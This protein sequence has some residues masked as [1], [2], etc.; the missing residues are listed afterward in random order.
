MVGSSKFS[1][2]ERMAT[3]MASMML[4]AQRHLAKPRKELEEGGDW[5]I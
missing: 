2:L 3:M 4:V 5:S 1:D